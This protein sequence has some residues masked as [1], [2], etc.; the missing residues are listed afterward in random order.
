MDAAISIKP[1]SIKG[2]S[3]LINNEK[4]SKHSLSRDSDYV[5]NANFFDR[6]FSSES[7]SLKSFEK[8]IKDFKNKRRENFRRRSSL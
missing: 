5:F 2:F 3:V 8:K 4:K 6:F 1:R 7:D